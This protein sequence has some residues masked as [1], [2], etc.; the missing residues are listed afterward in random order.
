MDL[1]DRAWRVGLTALLTTL[2]I[3]LCAMD[4]PQVIVSWLKEPNT[5]AFLIYLETGRD[6]RFSPSQEAV[7]PDFGSFTPDYMESPSAASESDPLPP[8]SEP[9]ALINTSGKTV[10]EAALLEEP[11]TWNLQGEDPTV[12]ILHTHSTE[13]YTRTDEPYQEVSAWRT[14]DDHYNMLSIGQEV[15]SLLAQAGIPT[16]QDRSYHDY[17]SYNGSYVDARDTLQTYLEDYPTI[18]LVLDL[19][20]DAAGTGANQLRTLAQVEGADSAQ[21]MIVLGTNH[22]QYEKNLALALKL[23][24][25]LEEMSPGIMR[26]LQLRPQRFNQDL[27]P[28]GLLIEV[29][30]AGN[31]HD[32]ALRAARMLAKAIIALADG[33]K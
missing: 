9:V 21:L 15:A 25:A 17:P 33:T 16:I 12:L 20:R 22:E 26:P 6:V 2:L 31:T 13:S 7:P 24:A 32:E 10:D 23:H 1:E 5:A 30:A 8:F 14:L 18:A 27:S 3:R 19:H 29:G 4:V 28:G 11:L